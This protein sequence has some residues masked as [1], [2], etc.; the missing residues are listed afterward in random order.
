M[1]AVQID[2]YGGPQ[3]LQ[4][5]DVPDPTAGPGQIVIKG[6]FKG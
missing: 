2:T 4:F 5:R 6:E 1:K 3:V